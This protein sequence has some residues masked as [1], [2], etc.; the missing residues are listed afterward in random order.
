M[1][2]FLS[3]ILVY[4]LLG[5][6]AYAEKEKNMTLLCTAKNNL[7]NKDILK[8]NLEKK[9]LEFFDFTFGIAKIS[10]KLIYANNLK[11]LTS[12]TALRKHVS[13]NRYT[14]EFLMAWFYPDAKLHSEYDFN[15]KKTKKI[16]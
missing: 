14:G 1:T 5:T 12:S 6:N 3:I 11:G 4:F 8:I 15:C 16:I 9:T 7:D 13:F 10:D 2:K